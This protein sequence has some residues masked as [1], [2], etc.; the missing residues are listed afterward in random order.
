MKRFLIVLCLL[1]PS[2]A[3]AQDVAANK[4]VKPVVKEEKPKPVIL[5]QAKLQELR[6][7]TLEQENLQ[8]KLQQLQAQ[9]ERLQA[10]AKKADEA[11]T[12]FW[13]TVGINRAELATKWEASNGVNGAIILT[14]KADAKEEK[15]KA[16]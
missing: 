9:A 6:L 8:L 3:T 16:Q 4:P 2:Y 13:R 14:P 15:P 10:D 1:L 7:V 11:I 5:D 12:A